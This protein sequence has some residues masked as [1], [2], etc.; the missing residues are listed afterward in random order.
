MSTSTAP[1]PT[2]RPPRIAAER[3][4]AW[5]GFLEAHARVT[6]VL[7]RELRD[8]VRLP[9]AWYDVLVQLQ[10]ADGHRLRMQEL[11]AA[12]LLSK[13]GLTRL[14][15]RMEA[16]GLVRR[17]ACADDRRG[18]FAELTDEGYETLRRTAPTHLRGVEEHFTSLLDDHEAEVLA[19]ALQRI[20]Q[21]AREV[22]ADA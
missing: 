12:V 9:L 6:D 5:R 2:G 3:L 11:A 8:E 1:T 21:H 17:T 15:D 13:S 20:A 4:A 16:E 7:A 10:E 14:V 19:R 18:T 22:E